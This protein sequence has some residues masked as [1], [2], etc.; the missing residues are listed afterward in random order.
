MSHLEGQ[1]RAADSEEGELRRAAGKERAGALR[2]KVE[3]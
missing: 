2:W 3:K 1:R